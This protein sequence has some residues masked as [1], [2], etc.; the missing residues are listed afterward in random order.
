MMMR[1]VGVAD[2]W[3]MFFSLI[4]LKTV[5][6]FYILVKIVSFFYKKYLNTLVELSHEK[7]S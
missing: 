2:Q 7:D 4:R 6:L 1:D 3:E 5:S